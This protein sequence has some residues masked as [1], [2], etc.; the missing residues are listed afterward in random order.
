MTKI[1]SII[2]KI[3]GF[4]LI[5][6]SMYFACIMVSST[7]FAITAAIFLSGI[8]ALVASTIREVKVS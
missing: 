3:I 8:I 2:S 4:Y 5:A 7:Q 6:V 1:E